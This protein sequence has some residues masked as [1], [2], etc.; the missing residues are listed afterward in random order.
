MREPIAIITADIH[1]RDTQPKCRKDNFF[2]AQE[3]KIEWLFRVQGELKHIP[4]LD[5]GDLF[6][7]WNSSPYLEAWGINRFDNNF[8]TVPGNHE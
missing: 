7:K 2:L 3:K 1:L 6:H 8:I 5:A 4:I